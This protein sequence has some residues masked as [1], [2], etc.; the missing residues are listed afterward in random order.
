M[1]K[2][3]PDKGTITPTRAANTQHQKFCAPVRVPLL[4]LSSSTYTSE[5]A[6]D[7]TDQTEV[8]HAPKS[9]VECQPNSSGA[10]YLQQRLTQKTKELWL[11]W[12]KPSGPNYNDGYD[13]ICCHRG[14]NILGPKWVAC[15]AKLE[16]AKAKEL[17]TKL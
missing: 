14:G 5:H 8:T 9:I 10:W 2:T 12:W 1:D 3:A 6:L 13:T 4:K 11:S 15:I 16:K 17:A 7:I